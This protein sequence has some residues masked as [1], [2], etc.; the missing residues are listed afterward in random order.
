MS[1]TR[2][3]TD[4]HAQAHPYADN[5]GR[6]VNERVQEL[7]AD[8]GVSMAQLALSWLLHD[9]RVDAPIV[10][11]SKIQHLEDAVEALGV[12]LSASD[13][14]YLEEPYEPVPVSGHE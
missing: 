12:S 5:G 10:G 4:D 11:A 2:A 1:T 6:A 9:E 7:A 8:R 14:A 13:L 3:E